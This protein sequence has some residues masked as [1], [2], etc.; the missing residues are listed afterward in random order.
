[1]QNWGCGGSGPPVGPEHP[2]MFITVEGPR[3]NYLQVL[4][5]KNKD[6]GLGVGEQSVVTANEYCVSFG[7]D[8]NVLKL[9]VVI[10]LL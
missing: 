2:W 7:G 8:E 3:T 4:Y 1:M 9:I 10:A 5:F 6:W